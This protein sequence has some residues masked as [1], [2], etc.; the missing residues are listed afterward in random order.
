MGILRCDKSIRY[1]ERSKDMRKALVIALPLI[2]T[3][4]SINVIAAPSRPLSII[5]GQA[6]IYQWFYPLQQ[7]ESPVAAE[8]EF[9]DNRK[10][11]VIPAA[12]WGGASGTKAIQSWVNWIGYDGNGQI[13]EFNL[14]ATVTNDLYDFNEMLN[15]TQGGNDHKQSAPN[16]YQQVKEIMYATRLTASFADDGVLH[17]YPNPESNIY[18]LAY[19]ELAWYCYAKS[20]PP[21]AS[22][23][24]GY[25]VPTW[26]FGDIAVGQSVTK[27]L[28]FKLYVPE[29]PGTP[30]YDLLRDS[31]NNKT[32]L[33]INRTG[34]LKISQYPDQ[35]FKDD[36]TNFPGPQGSYGSDVSVFYNKSNE[37]GCL[38]VSLGPNTPPN[39]FHPA[40]SNKPNRMMQL[41]VTACVNQ[42][43][44]L[45]SLTL[46]SG[47][48]GNDATDVTSITVYS[49]DNANGLID[50]GEPQVGFVVNPYPVDNGI[51]T[52]PI[53][54]FTL[55]G[56]VSRHLL[57]VY[58]MAT[59]TPHL[60]NFYFTVTSISASGIGGTGPA[61]VI[62]LPVT[63]CLKKVTRKIWIPGTVVL[64]PIGTRVYLSDSVVTAVFD[65]CIFIRDAEGASGI[66]VMGASELSVGDCLN[67]LEADTTLDGSEA[68]LVPVEIESYATGQIPQPLAMNG[69]ASGGSA[70]GIQPGVWDIAPNFDQFTSDPTTEKPS[71]G[72]SSIGLLVRIWGQITYS[73][74]SDFWVDDGSGLWDGTVTGEGQ[75]VTGIRVH[76]PT[77]VT[78]PSQGYVTVT[79]ILRCSANAQ[80]KVVRV[81]WPRT[82]EDV[83]VVK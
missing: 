61:S 63:S 40:M 37:P 57:I 76:P 80:G 2:A 58:H 75:Q 49:D 10:P 35:M 81:L 83:R 28:K 25:W 4:L 15:G 51:A 48:T 60:K 33:F 3:L 8:K 65:D 34:S 67:M 16:I 71:Y 18:A 22:G 62:G 5:T 19:D 70:S 7:G 26:V 46:Q 47:G 12:P 45:S 6:P 27:T 79:G 1:I 23:P 17:N 43:L 36:G 64:E 72:L 44:V 41:K 32:D 31:L 50:L 54:Y 56:L 59:T 42:D 24:S 30:L 52:I 39:H 11:D 21:Q 14:E 9:Y 53:S 68:A 73:D 13:T 69:R 38:R 77:G 66:K 78:F 20:E 74:R 82:E 55:P 29:P